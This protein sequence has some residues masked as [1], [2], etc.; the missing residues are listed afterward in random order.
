M[1][2][3]SITVPIIL[4]FL[5]TAGPIFAATIHVPGD[6]PMIQ[7]GIDASVD[8]DLVL[9][10]P[11]IYVE[12]INFLGKSITVQ[13]EAGADLTAIDGNQAGSVVT[14]SSGETEASV[15]DGFTITNGTGTLSE[16]HYCG[17]GIFSRNSSPTVS[18][19]TISGNFTARGGGI[20]SS[21]SSMTIIGCSIIGNI[22]SLGGGFH[23]MD[24]SPSLTGCVISE[25]M[26]GEGGG[27]RISSLSSLSIKDC[28]ITNNRGRWGGGI[29]ISYTPGIIKNCVI[30]RNR[31]VY[32]GGIYN[33][34]YLY[35]SNPLVITKCTIIDNTASSQGGGIY[36]ADGST[37]SIK[38]CLIQGNRAENGGGLFCEGVDND[39]ASP[40]LIGCTI[41][42]NYADS[43]GG[44]NIYYDA[45]ITMVNCTISQNSAATYGGGLYFWTGSPRITQCTFNGN[46]AASHGGGISCH[47]SEPKITNS[48][49]WG[50]SAPNGPEIS[51]D[52][53][54]AFLTV[55]YC[56]VQ[57]GEDG[58]YLV[59]HSALA[60]L[61]GNIAEDPLFVDEFDLHLSNRSPCI[62]AGMDSGVFSDVDGDDRPYGHGFDM[63]VDENVECWDE[64]GDHSPDEACGGDD[65]VDSNP[66][67]FAGAPESCDGLDND[68][69]GAPADDEV[70]SDGDGWMSCEGDC[71]DSD[72]AI[73][74]GVKEG[75]VG[76]PTCSDGIDND[77]NGMI[78][79]E[80]PH[81]YCRDLDED[82][83]FDQDCGGAD[84]N[85]ADPFIYPG[86]RERC[87]DGIDND[88][89]GLIDLEDETCIHV[90]GES[91]S[92]QEG[93]NAATDGNTVIVAPGTYR[94]NIN[95]LGKAIMLRSEAG[96]DETIINGGK[97]TTVVVFENGESSETVIDGF[98][99]CNGYA[100]YP[101]SGTSGGAGIRCHDASPLI[102]NCVITGNHAEVYG[103]G[104]WFS[105]YPSSPTIQN[106]TITGNTAREEI[107][108]GGGLYF[109]FHY[110]NPKILNSVITHNQANAG[111]GIC[112][113]G[114]SSTISVM[115]CTITDNVASREY[116]NGGGITT[117]SVSLEIANC[118]L[119]RNSATELGGAFYFSDS[120]STIRNCTITANSANVRG[121]G[122]YCSGSSITVINS[123][124]WD[125]SAQDG[126]EFWVGIMNGPS[127]ISVEYSDVQGGEDGIQLAL[128]CTLA[129]LDGNIDED[130]LFV[131]A[132]DFHLSPESPCIDIGTDAGV[133]FDMDRERRPQGAGFDIGADEFAPSGPVQSIII[134]FSNR[135]IKKYPFMIPL[136][137][138]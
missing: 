53:T 12:N 41:R 117:W 79:M 64:D 58:I 121:G 17:G 133:Y 115:N 126:K 50:N 13:S 4:S 92:I 24:G 98:T 5:F 110:S 16:L 14:F 63:G 86:A 34:E 20:Y 91:P 43:G 25:N 90:P 120:T 99:I 38:H 87:S 101:M 32:G 118:T 83:H 65:C 36:C 33:Y 74:P 70:D 102:L 103:G 112:L 37:S 88:C 11:G 76:H 109:D 84:C 111:G 21:D 119:A 93:I 27:I 48:I 77:C 113:R 35:S 3:R 82:G 60:W 51:V 23:F 116:G 95:F 57:G 125:D 127:Q 62:D 45:D 49:L 137:D 81:C 19:S 59:P 89:N 8:G 69:D 46:N 104:G 29:Y 108:S 73:H 42:G 15:L 67:I 97:V 136:M 10:A 100:F 40:T 44:V 39:I 22:G 134:P 85:D 128:F 114:S 129:W 66:I 78:D 26:A 124:F 54:K 131:G 28:T 122:L 9:V 61:D 1:P 47:S 7:E 75:P 132:E 123:I 31:A 135:K 94:E 105:G 106:C 30:A 2:V 96:P 6:Q 68:C 56:D 80:D 138:S 130:P 71:E 55:A 72:P 18:N 52:S 107:G